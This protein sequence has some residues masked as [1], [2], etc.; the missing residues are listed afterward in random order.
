MAIGSGVDEDMRDGGEEEEEEKKSIKTC[1]V[2]HVMKNWWQCVQTC[3]NDG[4]ATKVGQCGRNELDT[5][6]DACC[7]RANWRPTECVAK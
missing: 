6:A 3:I 7:T 2:R 4:E 1:G 5:H